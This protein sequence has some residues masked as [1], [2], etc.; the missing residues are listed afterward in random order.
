MASSGIKRIDDLFQGSGAP[1]GPGEADRE[2]VGAIHDLL[3]GLGYQ[4]LPG[5]LASDRGIYGSRTEAAVRGFR[6]TNGLGDSGS[7]DSP[8]LRRMVE[9]EA[10]E[11]IVSR[12]YLALVLDVPFDPMTNVLGFTAVM[13][14][15]GKF[16]ALNANTD[17]AGLSFGIIQWAQKP[18]RLAEILAAFQQADPAQFIRVFGD[19][20]SAIAQSLLDHT[21]KSGG[22]VNA[23]GLTTD[24]AFNLIAE[25]WLSRFRQAGRL[26]QFQVAQVRTA[27]TAFRSFYLK[28]RRFAPS[29]ASERGIAFMLDLANQHGES[30][31][32]SIF[33]KVYRPG[34]SE[35]DLLRAMAAES[36]TRVKDPFRA[37]TQK[38]RECFLETA[39]L[40]DSP[41]S[42]G[43]A[44]GVSA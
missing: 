19:S 36:V 34:I 14:G 33:T 8:A 23:Q 18:G 16:T 40:A 27:V 11:A 30:G 12:T 41:F 29:L 9:I 3:I 22:G 35:G 28:L 38:R 17:G 2:A 21:R 31:A 37:G 44:E 32:R 4:E 24:P 42:P 10:P 13:E 25:P 1:I 5:P 7:V 43:S 26:K 15:Q 20:D 39:L 6:S